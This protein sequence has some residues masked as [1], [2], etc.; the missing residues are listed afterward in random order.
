[1]FI[2]CKLNRRAFTLVE[3]LVVTAVIGIMIALLI[4]AVQAARESARRMQC[5]D[6]LKQL[7]LAVQ[8]FHDGQK[9]LPGHGTGPNQ[10]RSAFVRLLPFFEEVARYNEIV[11]LDDYAVNDS[12]NPYSDNACWKGII[13]ALLCPT[14]PG[15][16]SPYAIPGHATGSFAPTNYCF[17]E[18]DY[19]LVS[20]GKPGN[21]RSPFGMKIS[22]EWGADWGTES[23]NTFDIVTDGLSD[24][25]F[26]SERC[27]KPGDGAGDY[28]KIRGG[29]ADLDAWFS[30]PLECFAT[31]GSADEYASRVAARDGSG[32][33]FGYY[34]LHNAMFHTII[35]P[36]GPS[37]STALAGG[38]I[39]PAGSFASQ[40]A[41]T[42]CHAGGVNVCMGDGSVRFVGETVDFGDLSQWFRHQGN[43]DRESPSPFG[44]WGAMG[45]I[46]GGESRDCPGTL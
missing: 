2:K 30:T 23:G 37:C 26:F 17:S 28:R 22:P 36:N 8:H 19:V 11:S 7:G 9:R 43:A 42:S 14:D 41:P 46:N 33:L 35:P 44:I 34:K 15:S 18:A 45:S 40:L 27:V 21:D 25:A 39:H 32:S 12:N 16:Q 38:D 24:T 4:P 13:S 20:Y 6:R 3:L 10:N 29:I 1:M 31:K 5:S